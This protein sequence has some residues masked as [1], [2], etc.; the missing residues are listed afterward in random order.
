MAQ[1]FNTPKTNK[2]PKTDTIKVRNEFEPKIAYYTY[3]FLYS[4]I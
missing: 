4:K 1:K 2:T 3:N